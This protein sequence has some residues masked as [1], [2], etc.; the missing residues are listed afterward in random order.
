M[1]TERVQDIVGGMVTGNTETGITVTYDDSDGTLDFVV[2]TLN[3]DTT[4]NAATATALETAR[5]I[6]GVSFDGTGNI[7]LAGVN[8]TGNQDTS[9]NA[10]TATTLA[11]ART[12]GMTGDVVWTS[13]SF[14]GSGNVTGTATIQ[15]NSVALGT[16]TTGDYVETITGGTGITSTGATSGEGIAHTLSVDAAQTQIT[17]V[18]ALDG[19]SITSGF[20]SIDVGS[21]AITTTGTITG[22]TLAGTL[23]TAAQTNI[24]SVGTLTTLTVD[25]VII[26]GTTIGHTSDTDLMTLA[27]GVLTVAGELDATSLDISGNADIDGTLETDNL[28]IGGSQ[29]SDGQVL[30]STG[31]GVAWEDAG[32]GTTINNNADNRVITGSGTANTLEG[33]ANFVFDGTNVGIGTSSPNF[34]LGLHKGSSD[35]NYIQIT[36]ST[37]GSGASDGVLVGLGS[38]EALNVWNYEDEPINFGTNNTTRM[39]VDNDGDVNINGTFGTNSSTAFASM[40]GRLTFDTDYSDTQRGP[41]KVVLQEDGAWIAGLGVSNGATDFYTGGAF[42]FRT[43]TSLGSERMRLNANGTLMI[44]TATNPTYAHRIFADGNAITDGIVRFNDADVSVGLANAIL[45]LSFGSDNDCTSASF[46]YMTDGNGAIGSITAASGT[47]V[48]YNTT[49][50]ER[51]KKNIVDASSQLDTIKNIKIR[52][53]D[54]KKNDFHEVGVIAQEIKTVVPNAVTEGGDN[55]TK[56]PFGVDYGKIVPYLIKAV[57]EQQEQID[58]LQSEIKTLKGK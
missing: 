35:A 2:G 20:G 8:T 21:S 41:N 5:T 51:L 34:T 25:N 24:T 13:A 43:G 38:D 6:G 16:D 45:Q 1:T 36:N 17:S 3:Q 27:D 29:G 32:S 9:G 39:T 30:T 11:T 48:S 47:S 56:H 19:G 57:Q 52:E 15:A 31:S 37:T 4:G 33:E 18:G 10:A 26:D 23:S 40:G 58:A 46:V 44:G 55:E 7:D 53:F 54:W 14:D 28:T 42:T 22:G 49:S 12:I 50:D